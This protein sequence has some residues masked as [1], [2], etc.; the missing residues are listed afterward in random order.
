M[1]AAWGYN[2]ENWIEKLNNGLCLGFLMHFYSDQ[3]ISWTQIHENKNA[4]SEFFF[5]QL[6]I[7]SPK[8]PSLARHER[9]GCAGP[10]R[11]GKGTTWEGKEF[12]IPKMFSL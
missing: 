8:S 7:F 3:N 4:I 9:G 12:S 10:L 2:P 6:F 11:C 1:E 5:T